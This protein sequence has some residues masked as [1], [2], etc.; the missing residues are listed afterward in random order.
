MP[1]R[2]NIA[3][4]M[5][6]NR[7]DATRLKRNCITSG[8]HSKTESNHIFELRKT[9]MSGGLFFVFVCPFHSCF[10]VDWQS[11]NP[12]PGGVLKLQILIMDESSAHR[13]LKKV[14]ILRYR[15]E[16]IEHICALMSHEAR[17]DFETSYG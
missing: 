5:L 15:V 16:R 4:E 6:Y 2:N 7:M 14:D 13:Q 10:F 1:E 3:K 11:I 12:I 9:K 8:F 17:I